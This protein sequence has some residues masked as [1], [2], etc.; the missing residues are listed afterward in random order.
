MIHSPLAVLPSAETSITGVV[1]WC[2]ISLP[3]GCGRPRWYSMIVSQS[4]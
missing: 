2:R 1:V 4:V 3:T